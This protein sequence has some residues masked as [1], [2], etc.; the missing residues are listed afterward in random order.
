M[1]IW[2]L[3]RTESL[4]TR[5]TDTTGEQVSMWMQRDKGLDNDTTERLQPLD[6]QSDRI[7]WRQ[8]RQ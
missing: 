8:W 6:N 7:I 2:L 5:S 4:S 1:A 3:M